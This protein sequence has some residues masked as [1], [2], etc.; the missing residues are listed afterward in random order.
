MAHRP[1]PL[2]HFAA[3]QSTGYERAVVC[4]VS[5]LNCRENLGMAIPDFMVKKSCRIPTM[6]PTHTMMT[7]MKISLMMPMELYS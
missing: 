5:I 4:V 7:L 6:T 3:S 2:E 1:D